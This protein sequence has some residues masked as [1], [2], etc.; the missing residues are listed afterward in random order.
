[1]VLRYIILL[2]FLLG[3]VLTSSCRSH[4]RSGRVTTV[5]VRDLD[6]LKSTSGKSTSQK[7]GSGTKSATTADA[8][9]KLGVAVTSSDNQKLYATVAGWIGTPYK[10]G[11][12]S[13]SGVDCSGFVYSVYKEVYGKSLSRQS[14]AILANNCTSISK[15]KLREGDLVFFR[16]DGKKSST[17]NHVGIYLKNGKFVH[18][19]TSNGVVVNDLG[20]NYYVKSFLTGGR[21]K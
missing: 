19:S 11:G 3:L 21:V 17:P 16:T 1:M 10:Y 6:R 14:S 5:D 8:A 15:S 12:A 20:Q 4:R 7:G 2:L 9:K 13:K 18:A